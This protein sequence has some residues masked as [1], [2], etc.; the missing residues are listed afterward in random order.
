VTTPTARDRI[1]RA[2]RGDEELRYRAVLELDG[3]APDELDELLARL[4]DESWRVRSAAV[5]RIAEV[6]EPAPVVARLLAQLDAGTT[7]GSREAS[8]AALV[9]IGAP[10]LPALV[11]RLGTL[12]PGLKLAV[13]AV[14]GEIGE[15]RSVPA[16][17]A[18]LAEADPNLRATAAE[19]L[20]KIGGPEAAA[21][22]L[23]A[24]DSDDLTL[25]AS[26]LDA[27]C[28]IRVAPPCYRLARLMGDRSLRPAAYR[29]LGPSDEA[30]ALELLAG[31][32]S[33]RSRPAREAALG[34]IGQQRARRGAEPLSPLA[35]AA[36]EAAARDP[37][38]AD[39]CVAALQS[40]EP[41]VPIGALAVLT[42]VADARHAAAMARLADDD[43]YRPLVEEALEAM[44]RGSELVARLSQ[45]IPELSPLARLTAYG[46]LAEAGDASALQALI[47]GASD[48]DPHVQAEAIAALG[49]LGDPRSVPALA[50]LL[51]DDLPSLSGVAA[52]ALTRVAEASPVGRRAV[53]LE[54][55]GRAAA[56]PSSAIFR[57]LGAVGESEDLRLIRDGLAGRS[58][59]GRMAAAASV[60]ALGHRGLL[61]GQHL[62]ELIA[63]LGDVTW[64]VRAAA[65]RAFVEL[66]L[67]NQEQRL[68]DPTTGEH[69]ICAQAMGGLLGALSD[70]EPAVRAA[71]VEALGAC[72]RPEHAARI[73]EVAAEPAG[74][75]LVAVA[76]LQALARLGVA[77]AE[78]LRRGLDHADAEVAKEAVACAVGLAGDAGA[79]LLRQAAASPRWEVRY[80]VARALVQRGDASLRPDAERLAA[81]DPDPMVAKA[82]H[83]AARALA[84][85]PER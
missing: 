22:L 78:V 10:V 27:L 65:A 58:V 75:P 59:V 29:S 60:A 4:E 61:R 23:A 17:T 11:E 35:T 44:P 51:G 71:A 48:D 34:A 46:A 81:G 5:Q 42:W 16:L 20:G 40:S 83:E 49:R 24:L 63:A 73:A 33:E 50:G 76:A 77:T 55:R 25:Q 53:L 18:C 32:L 38:V 6:D 57:I 64:S 12:D 52:S 82:F 74:S 28:L 41:F 62:P 79:G 13:V 39:A 8:A 85:V 31:G 54:C 43:R 36:K 68:G 1:A 47:Y 56:S 3:N 21:G 84:R 7:V 14:L 19:A 69:P 15:R 45:V 30:A 72:G 37:G 66:A 70:P 2:H 67:A 9:R 80:A 26:A